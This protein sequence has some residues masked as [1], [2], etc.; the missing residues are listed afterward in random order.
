[1]SFSVSVSALGSSVA[2]DPEA[3]R[4]Q[5]D[6]E[7]EISYVERE[8]QQLHQ[9][10][11][12]LFREQT[13]TFIRD[14]AALRLE[15]ATIKAN[16]RR[17]ESIERLIEETAEK[18]VQ[19]LDDVRVAQARQAAEGAAHRAALAGRLDALERAAREASGQVAGLRDHMEALHGQ[20]VDRLME[21]LAGERRAR[22]A[23]EHSLQSQIAAERCTREL[24]LLSPQAS[25]AGAAEEGRRALQLAED[26]VAKE[27]KDRERELAHLREEV[28]R[29]TSQA[30]QRDLDQVL[31]WKE[32]MIREMQHALQQDRLRLDDLARS[33]AKELLH[34]E[35]G[36]WARQRELLEGKVEGLQ[37]A[38][39]FLER[40]LRRETEERLHDEAQIR[41]LEHR[42]L[43]K[44]ASDQTLPGATHS[45]ASRRPALP[46]PSP[47]PARSPNNSVASTS[48]SGSPA[49]VL[50]GSASF[51]RRSGNFHGWKP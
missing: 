23:L 4:K 11:L 40:R 22:E 25:A 33:A 26:L 28:A 6:W 20:Q 2:V 27:R 12:K 50:S 9:S 51:K 31:L 17:H 16:Q 8:G 24:L 14:L 46:A 29:R 37:H 41:N 48:A 49:A 32:N 13:A 5:A 45:S 36:L 18:Q 21:A 10:H 44:S 1:M 3:P 35:R 15:V 47:G 42:P 34:E 43:L 30:G 7:R 19:E 39:G 38:L